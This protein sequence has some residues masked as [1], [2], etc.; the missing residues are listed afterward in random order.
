MRLFYSLPSQERRPTMVFS[1]GSSIIRMCSSPG[2]L[3][4][5]TGPTAFRIH[6][7]TGSGH[8]RISR[9]STSRLL[10]VNVIFF[11]TCPQDPRPGNVWFSNRCSQIGNR[12]GPVI[13]VVVSGR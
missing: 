2:S 7:R 11:L 1:M 12:G 13:T 5:P 8:V 10:S 3:R 4:S 6:I 9:P